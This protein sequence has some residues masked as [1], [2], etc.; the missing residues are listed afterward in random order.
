MPSMNRQHLRGD[1]MAQQVRS[2][3]PFCLV[4]ARQ[5]V[6][7][8]VERVS[9]LTSARGQPGFLRPYRMCMLGCMLLATTVFGGTA[10]EVRRFDNNRDGKT[11][12]W[13]YYRDGVLLRVEVDRNQDGRADEATFDEQEKP[14]RAEFDTDGDG[15][16]NQRQ[17]YDAQGDVEHVEV[18][19]NGDGIMEQRLFYGPGKKGLRAEVDEDGDGKP[20]QWH[21]F[22]DGKL[23]EITLDA[24][25]D[26]RPDLGSCRPR[27]A[28]PLAY[29]SRLQW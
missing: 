14:I 24:N 25:R 7:S 22:K 21:I 17:F 29:H 16:V 4:L 6:G 18:D 27:S 5:I 8:V 28:T 26:G 11:D 9:E 10:E 2:L 12:H 23:D 20:E 15:K 3:F 19:R 13:E 1:D